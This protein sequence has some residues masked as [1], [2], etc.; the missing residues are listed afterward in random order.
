ME[1]IG[2][3]AASEVVDGTV[4]RVPKAYPVYDTNYQAAVAE[5][6]AY[7]HGFSNLQQ[8]G[9]NGQHR[10]NNQDHSMVAGVLA[11]RNLDGERHDVWAVNVEQEYHEEAVEERLV[12]RAA[13]VRSLEDLLRAAFSRYDE[14]AVGQA[15][16]VVAA[17]GL[18][19]ATVL[20]ML[21]GGEPRGPT[22]S[23]LGHYLLGYE[24]SW[25]GALLG[26]AEAG[27]AGFALGWLTAR[28]INRLIALQEIGLRRRLQLQN[29]LDPLEA[30]W[31]SS[32]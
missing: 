10:Y 1:R 17:V 21:H 12:P 22:L 5:I 3:L 20:L 4:L 32:G 16:G 18:F 25:P 7:L 8:V 28:W 26:A 24:V 19:A 27:L 30:D 2:I 14:V 6:R 11:A 23:L 31:S 29:T 15:V 13:T 9:R